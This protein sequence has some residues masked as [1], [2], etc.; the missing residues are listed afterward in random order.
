MCTGEGC[1]R[2]PRGVPRLLHTARGL[3]H[4]Q[5]PSHPPPL[6]G[7]LIKMSET[8]AQNSQCCSFITVAAEI[9]SGFK[10]TPLLAYLPQCSASFTAH[11]LWSVVTPLLREMYEAES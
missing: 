1:H 2:A 5:V 7:V 10:T 3:Q 8:R 9:H 6:L 11:T 4:C